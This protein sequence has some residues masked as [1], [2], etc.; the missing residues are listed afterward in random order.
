M[1]TCR[2][3][4]KLGDIAEPAR[5]VQHRCT[6]ADWPVVIFP[7]KRPRDFGLRGG[8]KLQLLIPPACRQRAVLRAARARVTRPP[9]SV[10]PPPPPPPCHRNVCVR[11]EE[12]K[13]AGV[14]RT[15]GEK[16]GAG[17]DVCG[18]SKLGMENPRE[19]VSIRG[20]VGPRHG[21]LE[22]DETPQLLEVWYLL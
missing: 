7:R 3:G 1:S 17:S 18:G 4:V 6:V 15:E 20:M 13:A 8:R 11:Q 14:A 2:V 19:A 16:P 10:A 5:C 9:L 12:A 22:L 21:G